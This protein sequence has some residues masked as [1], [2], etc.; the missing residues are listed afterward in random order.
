[1]G[2]LTH[3]TKPGTSINEAITTAMEAAIQRTNTLMCSVLVVL[4]MLAATVS[5]G[6]TAASYTFFE[7][8]RHL[9]DVSRL[10]RHN[11]TGINIQR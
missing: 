3:F 9:H 7:N 2:H 1:M 5:K 8:N 6:Q 11:Y 4:L 10:N